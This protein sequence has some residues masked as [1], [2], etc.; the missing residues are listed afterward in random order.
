MSDE[1]SEKTYSAWLAF[2]AAVRDRSRD[3][4][5]L[6]QPANPLQAISEHQ[7]R[8]QNALGYM[9]SEYYQQ[10]LAANRRYYGSPLG[11]LFGGLF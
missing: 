6:G 1:Y 3:W 4:L 10:V 11:S 7:A 2:S 8:M 9:Q 5:R